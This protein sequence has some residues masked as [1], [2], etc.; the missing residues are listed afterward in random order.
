MTE[1]TSSEGEDPN[2]DYTDNVI[3]PSGTSDS[4]TI[5]DWEW[6]FEAFARAL[7]D[8]G[9]SDNSD[10]Y[11]TTLYYPGFLATGDLVSSFGGGT[12][13]I[14]KDADN[15]AY[16][17]AITENFRTYLE[18]MNTWYNNGWLDT[19]FNER[20][21][22]IFFRI[23]ENGT[24]QGMVG[25][26]YSGQ[27]NLGTTI[28]VTCADAEDQQKAY[29]MPCACPINDVYGT[30]DQMY[31]EPDSFYQ[32]GR[33]SGRT[34]VTK[35]AE[36]KDLAALCT[37][38]DWLYTDE[39][40]RTLCWGLTSEQLASA[41]IENNLYEE[42]NIDGA[43]TTSTDEN[44]G[45]VYTMNYDMSADIGNALHFGRLIVGKEMTGAGAD[46][47]YTLVRGNTMI[48]DK[49]VQEWT[50]YTSTGSVID[51]NSLMTEEENAEYSSLFTPLNEYMSQNVP[52]LIKEGL[53]GWDEFV[54]DIQN[55]YH[56]ADLVAIYQGILDR[57]YR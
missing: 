27:G 34:A 50:R 54:D 42:N 41:D 24:A 51:Y 18:A 37:F 21:S 14:S 3:F 45:T 7:E 20:A 9:F 56:D 23:N 33:I 6:M 29:V 25:L 8:K 43:Y 49:S 55:T 31:K 2:N 28:R 11:C 1:F 39:G 10:A 47:D 12:G 38:F 44:G 15:N 17:S 26:W 52:T 30:E 16:D 5:S 19:R 32:G 36:D 57:L 13:S 4:L 46:L 22:D 35:A 40:A 48:V 53:G